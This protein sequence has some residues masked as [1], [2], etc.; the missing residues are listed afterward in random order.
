MSL[1]RQASKRESPKVETVPLEWR[2]TK[3]VLKAAICVA[4]GVQGKM[5]SGLGDDTDECLTSLLLSWVFLSWTMVR[6]WPEV[7][8][9][10]V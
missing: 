8:S 4:G 7:F 5:A 2:M 3:P 6:I 9:A 1:P 10:D